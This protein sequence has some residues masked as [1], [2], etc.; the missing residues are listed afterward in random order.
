MFRHTFVLPD[1]SSNSLHLGRAGRCVAFALSDGL[2]PSCC[3]ICG[4]AH[5]PEIWRGIMSHGLD[6]MNGKREK[7]TQLFRIHPVLGENEMGIRQPNAFVSTCH[8]NSF[9][10]HRYLALTTLLLLVFSTYA[11]LPT[12]LWHGV[13]TCF[14]SLS[15]RYPSHKDRT[16]Y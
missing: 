14:P 13:C 4:K 2:A 7:F 9:M 8:S 15:N 1:T 10:S 6:L 5:L 12:V 3:R 11:A 16:R